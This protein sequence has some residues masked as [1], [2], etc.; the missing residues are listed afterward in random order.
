MI[1]YLFVTINSIALFFYSIFFDGGVSIKGNIP[2]N[3][4]PGTEITAEVVITKGGMGGFAKLQIEVPEG[5]TIKESDSKGATFTFAGGIGK[6]IWTGIPGDA[7]F[8]VKFIIAV[9]ASAPNGTKSISGK[10]S[11]VENN[12]KQ[13]VEMPPVEV[14]VGEASATNINPAP[15]ETQP[16]T[17]TQP[18]ATETPTT[19]T[20]NPD[21]TAPVNAN[22]EPSSNVSA[23]RTITRVGSE[24]NVDIKI[25]KPAIKGF[26]RYSDNMLAGMTAKQGKL[27]GS[28][29]SVADNK[30]KFV[31]VNVPTTDELEIS[32]TLSGTPP[33]D[34]MLEGEFSYLEN[35]L[36]KA[37][38]VAA[39]KLPV[40]APPVT[41]TEA[42]PTNTVATPPT[43]TNTIASNPPPTETPTVA[44]TNP[45]PTETT[46]PPATTTPTETTSNTRKDGNVEYCVQI[47]AYQS[48]NVTTS[49][50]GRKYGISSAS[51]RSEMADGF[52]K[53][54]VGKF[55][56][57]KQ[58]RDHRETVKTKGVGGA[59]VAAYNG[60]KRITV[61]EALMVSNQKWYR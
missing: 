18:A 52:N 19:S 5:F 46:N 51:I 60:P 20:N 6:W 24:W 47:G 48:S 13:I 15:T 27:N 43:E 1:K 28:S 33:P 42:P 35:N 59:F 37:Y 21:P 39:E 41:T 34:A 50:L 8:P 7:E 12:A 38:K 9:D 22:A 53:F 4:K 40:D 56:E 29:F 44:A 17:T 49:A 58:A 45:P 57:Y 61:Q 16:V 25:K 14:I 10:Y 11:Y 55:G 3:I 36:S 54:M 23:T 2:G 31:W 26:A 32:Y 30:I